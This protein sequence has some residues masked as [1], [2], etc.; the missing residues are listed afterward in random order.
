[1]L[2]KAPE[3]LRGGQRHFALLVAMRVI[4][5]AERYVFATK[6]Q[7]PVAVDGHAVCIAAEV[8]QDLQR[9]PEGRFGVYDPILTE[10]SAQE[11]GKTGA[12]IPSGSRD[13]CNRSGGE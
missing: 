8:A 4:P 11:S 9:A 2:H 3:E 13:P 5:P 6:G 1:M 7:Q 10:Q 12:A